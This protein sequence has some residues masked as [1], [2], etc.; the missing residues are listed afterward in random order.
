MALRIYSIDFIKILSIYLV[1]VSHVSLYFLL[2]SPEDFGVLAARQSGQFGV[3]M[4][5]MASGY[6][7]LN[8]RRTDQFSYAYNKAKHV[9]IALIFWLTFYYF[10]DNMIIASFTEVEHHNFLA[11]INL[12]T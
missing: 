12:D 3:V 6:F 7:L 5:Y 11:F 2:Q 10:Y 9:G 4:F 1:I 8:N